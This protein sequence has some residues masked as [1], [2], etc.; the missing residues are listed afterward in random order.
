[1]PNKI[2]IAGAGYVRLLNGIL[3]A[4]NNEIVAL[5]MTLRK[6]SRK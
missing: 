5:Y 6:D 3:L 2:V 4:Q 1:M